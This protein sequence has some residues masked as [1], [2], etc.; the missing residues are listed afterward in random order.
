MLRQVIVTILGN[1]DS[2]KSSTIDIIKKS[3]IVKSEPGKITQSIKAYSVS[4]ET[5]KKLCNDLDTSKLKIPGL[6]LIDT[7]GHEAFI[8]LR[9]RGGS[10][11][12]IAILLIDINEGIKQQTIECIEIL[13][14]NKTPFVIVLNKIDLINGWHSRPESSL[15]KNIN[16]Q[17]ESVKKSI[18]NK[19]YQLVGDLYNHGFTGERF[20]KITDFTKT[21]AI[22]PVS[23]KTT[24][25][26]PEL[27]MVITGL[28]QKFLELKLE[29]NLNDPAEGT[30]LEITE[31]TGIGTCLDTIIYKGKLKTN[32]III[33]G[34]LSEPIITKVKAIYL[35]EKNKLSIVKE[36][37][38]AIGV[39]IS[40]QNI[41]DAIAGM[42]IKVA[43][44]D[45]E[46]TKI[47]IK[48]A[49]E[50]ITFELDNEGIVIKADTLGSL[51]ALIKLLKDKKIK[52]KRAS[53]GSITKKD[54][55]EAEANSNE[56]QKVILGFNVN[57]TNQETVKIISDNIIYSLVEKYESWF[58]EL[59]NK[60]EQ[61]QLKNL[62]KP[63]KIKILVGYI[64][65]QSNPAVVGAE[66]LLGILKP[67][68][69]L[70]KDSNK[71]T[72]AKSLQDNGKNISEAESGK[73]IAVSLTN[74]TIN[75]QVKE[76]DIL[77]SDVSEPH[78]KV[79]KKMKGSLKPDEIQV[80]K[81]IAEIKRKT[82]PS[83]GM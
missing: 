68:T 47:E 59:K 45:L 79:Y 1:I 14:H 48:S 12:D 55:S 17:S 82:N 27:L 25:G 10:L 22:I 52:I 61:G 54:I 32:D 20:D 24:E 2:G 34:T 6:L 11:A 43:N 5:I 39:K 83:W 21:I 28:A 74:V 26:I 4:L 51:E 19:L 29:H 18:D 63:C 23:A 35:P 73:S 81:E 3:S 64:F 60:L 77:Y 40:A 44:K 36:A 16:L 50:E 33:I 69:P 13:R 71:I 65:R 53:I 38:A 30:I 46:K 49:V 75:R 9:K 78:F 15:I 62:I 31:E 8:N 72:E 37:V 41:K 56:L 42:P 57:Q 70:M 58:K 80:L 66:V 76:G 67:G 7:P